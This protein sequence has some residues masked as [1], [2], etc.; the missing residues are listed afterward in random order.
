[1]PSDRLE[2]ISRLG[3]T[4]DILLCYA[5][6]K[7]MPIAEVE[8]QNFDA[9]NQLIAVIEHEY[10]YLSKLTHKRQLYPPT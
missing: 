7:N 6:G 9:C 10:S 8:A 3:L 1:M 5:I 4:V 2:N